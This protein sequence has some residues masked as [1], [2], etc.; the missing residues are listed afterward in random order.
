MA[1]PMRIRATEAGGEVDV[2]VLVKHDMETGQRKDAEGKT[3]PEHYITDI[4]AK[5]NDKVVFSAHFGPSV[6]KDPYINF[7]YKGAK[8]DKLVISWSDTK[9]DSRTD[10]AIVK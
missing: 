4:V 7:K 5:N 3:I 9:G 10:E 2:K 8:G 1:D 6:S